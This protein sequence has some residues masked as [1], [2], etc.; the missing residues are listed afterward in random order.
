MTIDRKQLS[1]L[2]LPVFH[3]SILPYLLH[4]IMPM[5]TPGMTTCNTAN[6]HPTATEQTIFLE[7]FYRI[8]WTSG[9]KPAFRT[10]PGRN[11]QL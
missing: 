7:G 5:P 1:V 11:N 3:T 4:G 10:E 6:G 8:C 9:R 2:V